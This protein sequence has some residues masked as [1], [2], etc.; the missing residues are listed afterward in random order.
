MIQARHNGSLDH[1]GG[2]DGGEEY[3]DSVSVQVEEWTELGE[4]LKIADKPGSVSLC[5]ST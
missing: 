4:G 2:S 1:Y 5:D 3:T